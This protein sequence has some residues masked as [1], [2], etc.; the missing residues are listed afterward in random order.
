MSPHHNYLWDKIVADYKAGMGTGSL[1]K[2]YGGNTRTILRYLKRHGHYVKYRS[3]PVRF[4]DCPVEANVEKLEAY[5]EKLEAY[6]E[7]LEDLNFSLKVSLNKENLQLKKDNSELRETLSDLTS[8]FDGYY[9]IQ[10]RDDF[11]GN[12]ILE[13]VSED[14]VQRALRKAFHKK[15][16]PFHNELIVQEFKRLTLENKLY[17][18]TKSIK[19]ISLKYGLKPTDVKRVL[20][21]KFK[22]L[23][24]WSVLQED[25]LNDLKSGSTIDELE[26]DYGFCIE[27]LRKNL[28]KAGFKPPRK[29]VVK[30]HK[31][32]S[33]V[34][35]GLI[36]VDLENGATMN[37]TAK[38]F[39]V[40]Y[41]FLRKCLSQCGIDYSKYTNKTRKEFE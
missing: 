31:D 2:K 12:V 1:Q 33:E 8:S 40:S 41:N 28:S 7:K 9:L 37:K 18:S 23:T 13:N 29:K 5:V 3:N 35:M 22:N 26:V 24:K 30:R 34:P 6:V 36:I 4:K 14:E 38:K 25:I 39:K 17:S 16:L 20:L 10:K 27:V 15:L 32:I 19:K 11:L 21:S